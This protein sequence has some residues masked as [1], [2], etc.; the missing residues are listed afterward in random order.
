M[1]CQLIIE[2]KYFN[3]DSLFRG[4]VMSV[5]HG[6]NNPLIFSFFLGVKASPEDVPI[7]LT[8]VGELEDV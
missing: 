4:S 5:A 1:T 2:V 8:K 7:F 3:L 6:L